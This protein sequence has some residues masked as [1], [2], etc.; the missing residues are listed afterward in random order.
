VFR[1]ISRFFRLLWFLSLIRGVLRMGRRGALIAV[2]ASMLGVGG[3]GSAS[4]LI[5]SA[6]STASAVARRLQALAPGS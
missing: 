1:L 2:L 6:R 4:H 5:A 3:C